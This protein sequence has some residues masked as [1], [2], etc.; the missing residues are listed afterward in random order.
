[1]LAVLEEELAEGALDDREALSSVEIGA[2]IGQLEAVD[3]EASKLVL[4]ASEGA[5][6]TRLPH[7]ALA[8]LV[9]D[10]EAFLKVRNLLT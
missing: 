1:M 7:L 4:D 10:V 2:V 5:L 6:L 8:A 9:A 3:A